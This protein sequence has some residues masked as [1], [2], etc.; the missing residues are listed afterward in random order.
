MSRDYQEFQDY[1][2][3][4]NEQ[5]Y[6]SNPQQTYYPNYP[7]QAEYYGPPGPG[8]QTYGAQYDYGPYSNL[9][10]FNN[11]PQQENYYDAS[12]YGYEGEYYQG[13]AQSAD[14]NQVGMNGNNA[15]RQPA[16]GKHSYSQNRNRNRQRTDALFQ[17]E[18]RG[19]NGAGKDDNKG[20]KSKLE[21]VENAAVGSSNDRGNVRGKK[22]GGRFYGSDT[23]SKPF[24]NRARRCDLNDA[25]VRDVD[26]YHNVLRASREEEKDTENRSDGKEGLGAKPKGYR[27]QREDRGKSDRSKV[28]RY[29]KENLPDRQRYS[30]RRNETTDGSQRQT[31]DENV[32][33][34]SATR[35]YDRRVNSQ[36]SGVLRIDL[37]KDHSGGDEIRKTGSKD[38]DDRTAFD[39]RTEGGGSQKIQQGR[40]QRRMPRNKVT[41]RVDESQRGIFC[42][43]SASA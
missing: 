11:Y 2:Y 3:G 35:D 36:I 39:Y 17:G 42:A 6:Y 30:A 34:N 18:N 9:N 8:P 10:Y 27:Q 23:R 1:Q 26:A 22:Q 20:D 15:V 21:N 31:S 19:R 5:Y 16:R 14:G 28:D 41:K 38:E 40:Y 37:R 25:I 12:A 43:L 13:V 7:V 4:N 33:N 24:E 32:N 29:G